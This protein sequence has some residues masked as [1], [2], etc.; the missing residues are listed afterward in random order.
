[1][2]RHDS[3]FYWYR[4]CLVNNWL[5]ITDV[6]LCSTRICLSHVHT[7]TIMTVSG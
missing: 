3:R 1:M 5:L 4:P 7:A 2:L 6:D